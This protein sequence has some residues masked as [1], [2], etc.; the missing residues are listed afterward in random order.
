VLSPSANGDCHD[1]GVAA[2][3]YPGTGQVVGRVLSTNASAGTYNLDFFSPENRS[4][5]S[6][7]SHNRVTLVSNQTIPTNS[8]TT[9]LTKA[10]TMP[11]WGCPCRVHASYGI[12]WLMTNN[13]SANTAWVSDATNTWAGSQIYEDSGNR[14]SG[15]NASEFSPVTYTANQN[16]TFTLHVIELNSG[17]TVSAAPAAGSAPNTYLT[18]DVMTSN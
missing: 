15:Q 5:V 3:S 11:A 16:V 13:G 6:V 1:S 12:Y 8:D 2:P 9:I 10:V 4:P 14:K 7:L 18:L 17:N